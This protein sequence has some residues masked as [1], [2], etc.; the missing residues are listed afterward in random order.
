MRGNQP[1]EPRDSLLERDAEL[2]RLDATLEAVREGRGTLT[3]IEGAAGVGKSTLLTYA[4]DRAR[5]DDV[6]VLGARA[7]ELERSFPFGVTIQ[8]LAEPVQQRGA[9]EP[10]LV[11]GA[12]EL[13]MPLLEGRMPLPSNDP[14]PAFPLLHGLH[15]LVAGLAER[16]PL[17]IAIDDA[18]WADT[19]SLRFLAYLTQRLEALPVTVALTVRSGEAMTPEA[20]TLLARLRD[21]PLTSALALAPLSEKSAQE[22][23]ARELPDTD[24]TLGSAFFAATDGNPFLLR[25]LLGA[26]R[27]EDDVTASGVAKLRPEAVRTSI[28]VRLG[29]LGEGARRLALAVAVLG[30]AASP[31]LTAQ[32][33]ELDPESAATA[34]DA[35]SAAHI[36]A[37]GEPLAFVHSI[38]RE[39]VYADLP[40]GRRRRDHLHSARLLRDAGAPAE[41]IA[42]H[43]LPSEPVGEE[44]AAAALREAAGVAVGRGDPATAIELLLRTLDEPGQDG[45]PG[46]LLELG[47]AEMAAA[48]AAAIEHLE[49]ADAAAHDP[50]QRAM[51]AGAIGQARWVLGDARGAFESA[52]R[53]LE[54]IPPGQGGTP[55]AELLYHS[56]AAGRMAPEVV[57]DVHALLQIPREGPDGSPAAAEIARRTLLS[58]DAVLRGDREMAVEL[59]DWGRTQTSDPEMASVLLPPPAGVLQGLCLWLLGRYA[60]AQATIDREVKRAQGRGNLLELAM[61]LEGRI[62]CNWARGDVNACIADTETLL[63]LNEEG[64]ETATVPV[65]ALAAEMLLER[66]DADGAAKVLAPAAEVEPRLPG[67]LGWYFLPYGRARLALSAGD[68]QVAREQALA[69]GERLLAIQAPSPDYLPW[70][71]LAARA[72]ARLE[73]EKGALSLAEEELELARSIGSRRATGVALATLGNIRGADGGLDL[74]FEAVAELDRTEAELEPARTRLELGIALRQ[75]RRAREARQPLEEALDTARRLGSVNL[76][77]RALGELRAAGGRPRRLAL[78]GVES[79]TPGQLRVAEMAAKGMSN[80]E[81]A[82]ALFVTRRTVETHLTQ[83]YGKLEIGSREELPIALKAPG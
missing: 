81:I 60:E 75:A 34:V 38:V 29:R 35:L 32:L 24:A 36:L 4:R 31:H 61:C 15:W 13:A 64:W 11:S 67:T 72:A 78:S 39:A 71:S 6:L 40:A 59:V 83:V 79:L 51:A 57:G 76:A 55:E 42:S 16:S 1:S 80:R 74:H 10:E 5:G 7:D 23:V 3:L 43:L 63:G 44:W 18:H 65:R 37:P 45:D 66:D 48:D 20:E 77:E 52:R 9:G 30:P 25:E 69:I 47:R 12:A 21:H 62:G 22:L 19:P 14:A 49:A 54:Q 28:L 33:A 53:A 50:L 73:D 26:A 68:W 58:F 82:E 8:L 41:E 56:M 17:L 2:E 27:Q 46:L 70:R